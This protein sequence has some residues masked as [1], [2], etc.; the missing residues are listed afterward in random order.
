ML[1]AGVDWAVRR[2]ELA[3]VDA[4][5]KVVTSFGF[6][7]SERGVLGMLGRLAAL[8]PPQEIQVAIERPNGLLVERLL[9]AGHAV[10]P[11]H[12]NA[13]AAAR[14]R[15][16][17]SGAKSDPGDAYR[18]ADY[19]RTDGHRL[20]PLRP[21]EP[22]LSE[23]RA[24]CRLRDAQQ[25]TRIAVSN[26]LGALLELHWPGVRFLFAHLHSPVALAFLTRYPTPESA[27]HLGEV[28]M[29]TFLRRIGY[30]GHR[31][32]GEL[33]ERLREAPQP[34]SPLD[35]EVLAVLVE[36]QVTLLRA[37]LGTLADLEAAIKVRLAGCKKAMLLASLPRVGEVN[38]AQIVA[39]VGP[40]LERAETVELV[41]AE[42]GASPVTRA[43]GKHRSVSFLHACNTRARKALTT[44][45]DNSRRDSP[46]AAEV[47]RRARERGCRHPHA[48]RILARAW[49]RVIWACWHSERPYDPAQH[50]VTRP[51]ILARGLT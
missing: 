16:G 29:A 34:V 12:P 50:G 36:A 19:L 47:Y 31:T 39:E 6:A 51:V 20:R 2:H 28:R 9:A 18:L 10:Y 37:V 17:A 26:Q 25:K 23:L 32:A 27:A 30:S 24:L 14:P 22:S 38:L 21:E 7:H 15:W 49:L 5:G 44:F 35:P 11:V 4:G 48:I 42:V 43:S 33:L 8:A 45:A 46:W 13:F 40:I 1:Y 3:V 41:S